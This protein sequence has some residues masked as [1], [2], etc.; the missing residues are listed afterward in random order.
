[1]FSEH[2]IQ[3]AFCRPERIQRVLAT[4]DRSGWQFVPSVDDARSATGDIVNQE[5]SFEGSR[6]DILATFD[7]R[8][9]LVIVEVKAGTV[10]L[11][12][13]NQLN[14]YLKD[15]RKMSLG[16]LGLQ[17]VAD[18]DVLGI[19][20]AEGFIGI[21]QTPPN[22]VLLAFELCGNAWPF[23]VV[24]PQDT[25]PQEVAEDSPQRTVKSSRLMTF[26]E[27]RDRIND[28]EL[29]D[30]F[31]RIAQCFIDPSDARSE[32]VLANAKGSHVAVHYKGEY[33]IHLWSK[34]NCFYA[35]YQVEGKSPWFKF[36]AGKQFDALRSVEH[37][38]QKMLA[39]VDTKLF[40][41]IPQEFNWRTAT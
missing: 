3:D 25:L 2:F 16:S 18:E 12:A 28:L 26:A 30:A 34:R 6:I 35:G 11:E 20:L 32:W 33:L 36:E 7:R 9:R 1:M 19:V 38:C 10:G 8:T 17:N 24:K 5:V 14:A 4:I 27:H 29:R 13:L 31:S 39:T 21:P 41:A 37:D 15:W 40:R 22:V 23:R